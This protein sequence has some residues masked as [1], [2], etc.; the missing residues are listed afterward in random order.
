M[1]KDFHDNFSGMQFVEPA[2]PL[3]SA[4]VV[5]R[6]L[7]KN[8]ASL[9]A[10]RALLEGSGQK[11]VREI[12]LLGHPAS[13]LLGGIEESIGY[14]ELVEVINHMKTGIARRRFAMIEVQS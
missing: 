12:R 5:T 7:D 1:N 2:A 4:E 9:E 3:S 6:M 14:Y 11:D 13:P 8:V 10:L